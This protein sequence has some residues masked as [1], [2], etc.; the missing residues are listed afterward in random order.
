MNLSSFQSR[1][2]IVSILILIFAIILISK[3]FFVQIIHKN[4]YTNKADRQYATPSGNIFDRGSIFFTKKDNSL[5]AAG[6]VSSGFKIAINVKNIIDVDK[7]YESLDPYMELNYEAFLLK[8]SKKNDPYEE[9]AF[10]LSK[11]QATEIDNLKIPGVSIFKDNWRFYPGS[12]LASHTLGFLAYKGD[13]KVGQYGLERF[14]NDTLS[15]P[16]DVAYV[17]FFA[18]VFS[19]IKDSIKDV[20]KQGDIVTTIEPNTQ[21]SLETELSYAFQK[22]NADQA[23][24][25]IMNPQTGEIY[26]IS[27]MPD[28]NLNKFGEV[29]NPSIYRNIMVEDVLEFGSVIKPLVMSAALDAGAVMPDTT[30]LDKGMVTVNKK[31][32]YNF[33]KKGRGVVSMQT[34]LDQSLN[35]GMVFTENKLGHDKFREYMKAYGIGNKTGIDLPNETSGLIKNLESPR[36]IEYANA[37]FG[38]GI[39]M[40]PIEAVKAFSSII[41]GGN[42]I[43]PHLVKQIRYND[44]T[45]K[46]LEYPIAKSGIIKEETS[47]TINR[48]LVHVFEAYDGGAHKFEHYSVGSKTGTAQVAME[49]GKGYYTDRHTHSFFGYFPAYDP[50]FIVF[51]FLKNPKGVQYASQ[52]LIPSFMNITKFLLN[53][54]NVPPDR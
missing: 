23:G 51:I 4:L 24:G 27:G 10:H 41:N 13:D 35:T 31:D 2:R 38:Q 34:V 22:W 43:T 33:D 52:S 18:E 6:T 47:E 3:L 50:Q 25:I 26:A 9:V 1:I 29:K 32:I 42:A 36:D 16:K 20:K 19:N 49:N 11:E 21:H 45:S 17:N 54:Y 14:Y 7:T 44:G 46:I 39:A 15:K 53:Y 5:V 37:S 40:T 48:M 28:F 30:Y 8:A 12:S